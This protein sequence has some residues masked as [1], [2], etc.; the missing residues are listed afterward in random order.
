MFLFLFRDGKLT[1]FHCTSSTVKPFRWEGV[2]HRVNE[3]LH[4]YPLKSAVWY[5]HLRFMSSLFLF[6]ISAIFIHFIPAYILDT[7][8]RIAGGRPILVRLHT[9][10]W[11]SLNLLDRFIFTEWK[12]NNPKTMALIGSQTASDKENFNIDL[13]SLEWEDYFV[14]LTLGV[15]RYLNHEHPKNLE[16]AR[17][18]DT[19]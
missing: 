12:F 14:S 5:P 6:K 17:G 10:V 15:R 18:K 2:T 13:R 19:L 11:N 9:N 3:F 1:I 8:T 7:F 16:A 4:R